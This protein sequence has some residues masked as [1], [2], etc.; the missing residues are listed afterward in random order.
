MALPQD[1]NFVSDAYAECYPSYHEMGAVVVESDD[2]DLGQMDAKVCLTSRTVT[3]QKPR[4]T[5]SMA[6][7]TYRD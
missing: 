3:L 2:E 4:D 7:A 5:D 6:F 1:P